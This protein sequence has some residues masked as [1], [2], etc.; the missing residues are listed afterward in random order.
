[1]KKLK[2]RRNIIF[3]YNI[4]LAIAIL[5]IY[6][7][8][9]KLLNYGPG[10]INT[11]FD[12]QM[13]GGLYYYQQIGLAWIALAIVVT[14]VLFIAL[15]DIDKYKEIKEK[16]EK[17]KKKE[18]EKKLKSII[19][20]C[21][22]L[23]NYIFLTC[24]IIP[25]IIELVL[26]L[27]QTYTSNSDFKLILIVFIISTLAVSIVNIYVKKQLSK[28]LITLK[29][30]EMPEK[31]GKLTTRVLLQT[32]PILA[33]SILFTFLAI[34]SVYEQNKGTLLS[35]YYTLQFKNEI[36][37]K[38]YISYEDLIKEINTIELERSTDFIFITDENYNVIHSN[39]ELTD[40][41]KEYAKNFVNKENRIV[42]D[43]YGTY[44][45]GVVYP[46]EI[47]GTTYYIGSYYLIYSNEM[48]S[49][50]LSLIIFIFVICVL[51]LIYFTYQLCKEIREV[52]NSLESIYKN[53]K[54]N[55]QL[56]VTSNDEIGNLV[57]S[58]NQIQ[59]M[60]QEHINQIQE[61]Q[62]TLMEQERMAALGQLIG[63]IAHNLKTPIM[64]ISGATEGLT[65]LIKEYNES[66]EDKEVTIEDHHDIAKDMTKWVDKIKD[67]TEYMSDIITAVKGQ[68]VTLSEKQEETFTVDE[69][70]KRVNILMK[71]E[72]KSAL[73]EMKVKVT[74]K[75]KKKRIIG[76]VNSLVQ[77]INN[78]IQNAI[79]SY[80]INNEIKGE[81]EIDFTI[82]ER[83]KDIVFTIQDYGCG[84]N[85]ETK[86]KLFKEMITTKGKN[87]TGLGLFMSYSTI[88][89]RFNG[90]IDFKSEEGEGSTFVISIP[91]GK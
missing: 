26:L 29:N 74:E 20:K 16:Y 70:L 48:F 65:D 68:A 64:S 5:L 80:G 22:T 46:I 31:K 39:G 72:L 79:Q 40:F 90:K 71:H 3:A 89:G 58:M 44:G 25:I 47:N 6:L 30:G 53:K 57:V 36:D 59:K 69:V 9:P 15:K 4:A 27:T 55:Q 60:N 10:T 7:L 11:E 62:D 54:I 84:M 88:K 34:S 14:I 50:M 61:N 2:T 42:Y 75:V 49:T 51:I 45:Q 33:V 52:G 73:V 38:K 67:Y 41:F 28:V 13:S 37:N 19:K 83:E 81:K 77:I 1:M 32:V 12:K 78:L 86:S 8:I 63:G 23:P 82:E 17:S 85:E 66:I 56:Y 91:E 76:D 24:T 87:G 35:K 43:F 18:Y 21:F